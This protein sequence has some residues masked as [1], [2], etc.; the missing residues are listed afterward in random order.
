MI[1]KIIV[2]LP[3]NYNNYFKN[4]IKKGEKSRK[5]GKKRPAM[6][7]IGSYFRNLWLALTGRNPY[8]DEMYALAEDLSRA[9]E[10][11]DQ[12][13][14]KADLFEKWSQETH[15]VVSDDAV[16][17]RSLQRL[18]E[19]Q[20]ERIADKEGLIARM[21]EEHRKSEQS[22]QDRIDACNA[23]LAELRRRSMKKPAPKKNLKNAKES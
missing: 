21:Q 23:Q 16:M 13:S 22:Y 3:Q 2:S 10:D 5:Y 4:P 7:G 14:E 17:I 15:K 9:R 11:L 18:V 19:N 1:H 6:T 12:V 20:R 8:Q